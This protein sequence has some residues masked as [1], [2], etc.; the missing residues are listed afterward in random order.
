LAPE[1]TEG[2]TDWLADMMKLTYGFR[3]A[4]EYMCVNVREIAEC[5]FGLNSPGPEW[6]VTLC[7]YKQRDGFRIANKI[8]IP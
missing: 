8:G 3:N 5:G 6:G 1:R 2:Q 7:F 4:L